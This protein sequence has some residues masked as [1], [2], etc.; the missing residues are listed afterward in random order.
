MVGRYVIHVSVP[1]YFI[2]HAH[3]II[4]YYDLCFLR[5]CI[6]L[7]LCDVVYINLYIDL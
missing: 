3:I 1:P 5:L 6:K 7:L 2:V 4:M